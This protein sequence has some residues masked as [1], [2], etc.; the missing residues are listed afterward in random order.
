MCPTHISVPGCY[1]SKWGGADSKCLVIIAE[2][3]ASLPLLKHWIFCFQTSPVLYYV[4]EEI[5][6]WVMDPCLSSTHWESVASCSFTCMDRSGQVEE[7]PPVCPFININVFFLIFICVCVSVY[8][9]ACGYVCA[10]E[11][12]LLFHL[13]QIFHSASMNSFWRL[14]HQAPHPGTAQTTCDLFPL[15]IS[16]ASPQKAS[17]TSV[18]G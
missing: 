7:A 9:S 3:F 16:Q 11:Y 5:K 2:A 13:N 15:Q 14:F 10:H 1:H 12:R 6:V 18:I 4:Q 17:C 8:L